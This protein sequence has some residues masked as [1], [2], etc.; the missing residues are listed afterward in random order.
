MGSESTE[1]GVKRPV[2]ITHAVEE[3]V[4]RVRR[5]QSRFLDFCIQNRVELTIFTSSGATFIGMVYDHDDYSLLFGGRN[6]KSTKR[7]IRKHFIS[8]MVP[9]EPINL[10]AEYA[11]M[12]TALKRRKRRL[13]K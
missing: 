8:L 9:K 13:K 2:R 5:E 10:F 11:G 12:G 6:P 4:D 1:K 3:S 7:M